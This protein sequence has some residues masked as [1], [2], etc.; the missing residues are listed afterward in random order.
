[1]GGQPACPAPFASLFF[2]LKYGFNDAQSAAILLRL[3]NRKI[4]MLIK[5]WHLDQEAAHE[6]FPDMFMSAII[7]FRADDSQ[8]AAVAH[9]FQ[10]GLY[11][12]VAVV[13]AL[14]LEEAWRLTNHGDSS[15]N[16]NPALV[17][18][19]GSPRSSSVGDL[20]E[21]DGVWSLCK[22]VGFKEVDF[23]ML[24]PDASAQRPKASSR[25]MP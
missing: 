21:S 5:V 6:K 25:N 11:E 20:F 17:A 12:M 23:S 15:W 9:F 10:Q 22:S 4:S 19:L 13:P 3:N 24:S 16:E 18:C 7:G 2:L 14:G 1:M 8:A